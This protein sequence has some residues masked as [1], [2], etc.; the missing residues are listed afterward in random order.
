MSILAIVL[1]LPQQKILYFCLFFNELATCNV[2][3]C[4]TFH[5]P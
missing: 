5:N 3:F 2:K 4:N 1:Q